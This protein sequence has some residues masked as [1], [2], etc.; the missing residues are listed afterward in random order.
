MISD[1]LTEVRFRE[2]LLFETRKEIV[3]GMNE[4]VLVAN[5]MSGWPP[6]ADV[7]VLGLRH[8]NGLEGLQFRRLC[9][10]VEFQFVHALQVEGNTSLAAVNLEGVEVPAAA[11]ESRRLENSHAAILEARQEIGVIIDRDFAF[12][13][14]AFR[15]PGTRAFCRVEAVP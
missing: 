2:A 13:L 8:D 15:P 12:T 4:S 7:G 14:L 11:G 9:A 10:I 3:Y 1:A 5:D 6:G